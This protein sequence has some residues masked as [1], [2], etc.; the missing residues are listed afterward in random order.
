MLKRLSLKNLRRIIAAVYLALFTFIFI[1]FS[2]NFSSGFINGLLYLQFTPSLLKFLKV[3]GLIAT[4]FIVV[5]LLTLLFGRAYCSFLCPLG[6]L[7][8]IMAR[9]RAKRP[10]YKYLKPRNIVRYAIL[11]IVVVLTIAGSLFML[12]LL[13]PY[14]IA[15][16]IFSDFVRPAYYGVNNFFVMILGFFN[17]YAFHHVDFKPIPWQ[18]MAITGAVVAVIGFMAWK[19]GRLYCNSICPVGAFLSLISRY[20][21]F[22]LK[23]DEKSCIACNR[24]VR[25]CKAGCISLKDKSIDFSRCVA[26]YNCMDSCREGSI[27]YQLAFGRKSSDVPVETDPTRRSFVTTFAG[28]LI[29]LAAM[30]WADKLFAQRRIRN[31]GVNQGPQVS[32]AGSKP[33]RRSA[34]ITP[35]GSYNHDDYR[36]TCTA[37]HLCVTACPSH[38]L[39]PSFNELGIFS[40]L[41]PHMDFRSGFCNYECTKCS[42]VCPTG[43]IRLLDLETKKRTQIGKVVFHRGNCIVR[44]D[45]TECGA[46]SEHCPTKAVQMVPWQGLL[47]PEVNPEICIGCGACEH[48]CPTEPYKAIYVNGN[49]VHQVAKMHES[50]GNR[51]KESELDDFPF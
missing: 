34:P 14:S 11:T 25:D 30:G 6:I 39:Q 24:C 19:W 10:R 49:P 41:Q 27:S 7:Q 12:Y 44:V 35:P 23:I 16:R 22:R 3:G 18:G 9:L 8:D 31:R 17:S 5:L 32:A 26:C 1:D 51:P 43:A 28:M 4:G 40:M 48:A 36:N 33:N 46:C 20:S 29:G 2:E 21:L 42:E 47:I 50:I 15:G 37:C 13:D 38:V 45:R